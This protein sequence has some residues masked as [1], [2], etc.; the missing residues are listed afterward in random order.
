MDASL[1]WAAGLLEGD[2]CISGRGKRTRLHVSMT[3]EETVRRFADVVRGPMSGPYDN[4]PRRKPRWNANCS[5]LD[6]IMDLYREWEPYLLSR[7][8]ARF[9]E[10][11][12]GAD[13]GGPIGDPKPATW[14]WYPWAAGLFEAEGCVSF[15]G[16][17]AMHLV[18]TDKDVVERFAEVVGGPVYGPYAQ[19]PSTLGNPRKPQFR[20]R[21]SGRAAEAVATGLRPWLGTRRR[22]RMDEIIIQRKYYKRPGQPCFP[23]LHLWV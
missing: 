9:Q 10:A 23:G 11:L 22:G 6:R 20:W 3:D 16:T 15:D 1:A 14:L 8:R 2:G 13:A 18:S 17:P 5:N 7:R 4:G 12:F 19:P 21:V